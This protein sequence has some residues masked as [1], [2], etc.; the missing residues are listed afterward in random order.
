VSQLDGVTL[1][2]RVVEGG[3]PSEPRFLYRAIVPLD[4]RARAGNVREP[5]LE[6]AGW[7][8][9]PSAC[10]RLAAILDSLRF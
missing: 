4:E 7:C 9:S 6:I 1:E 10:A 3:K 5:G 8:D 2:K